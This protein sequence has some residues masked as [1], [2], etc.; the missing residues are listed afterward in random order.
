M[1]LCEN[2]S[3]FSQSFDTT[4]IHQ[5]IHKSH[6]KNFS[7]KNFIPKISVDIFVLDIFIYNMLQIN[8]TNISTINAWNGSSRCKSVKYIDLIKYTIV[9]LYF[10]KK[11]FIII[12]KIFQQ[13][14]H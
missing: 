1:D 14:K 6:Y 13:F 9:I 5:M 3:I 4:S 11:Q 2:V 10:S 12:W 8:F 7:F